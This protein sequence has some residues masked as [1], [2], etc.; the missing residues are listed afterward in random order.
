MWFLGEKAAY[1]VYTFALW[2]WIRLVVFYQFARWC[3]HLVFLEA[4]YLFH[5]MP[6]N[7]HNRNARLINMFVSLM[8]WSAVWLISMRKS[9]HD[10][11]MVTVA[12]S[13]GNWQLLKT[14]NN[15]EKEKKVLIDLFNVSQASRTWNY[16]RYFELLRIIANCCQFWWQL[17]WKNKNKN[18]INGLNTKPRLMMCLM[19]NT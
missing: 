7:N 11:I 14:T 18:K 4:D 5:N 12:R 16:F 2:G 3:R 10:M 8:A 1:I 6:R 9:L 19:T 15:N 17:K 13:G